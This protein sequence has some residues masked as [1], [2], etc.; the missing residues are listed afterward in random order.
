MTDNRMQNKE[1][2]AKDEALKDVNGK[3]PMA[4]ETNAVS[5]DALDEVSGGMM[6]N[7]DDSG[8]KKR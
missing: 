6:W 5:D 1:N 4:P 7:W 3:M 8:K 2:P